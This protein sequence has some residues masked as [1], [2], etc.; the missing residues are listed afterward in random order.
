ML[1]NGK[2]IPAS[3]AH[4]KGKKCTA[5]T[6]V[7]HGLHSP[8]TR[9]QTRS[10]LDGVLEGKARLSPGNYRLLLRASAAGESVTAKQL[11]SF[12]LLG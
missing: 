9:A 12:T 7:K 5:Y 6:A 11:P 2:C 3:K 1:I 8:H 4:G 10:S